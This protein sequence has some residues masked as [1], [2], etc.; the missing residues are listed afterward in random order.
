MK[1]PSLKTPHG[2][3][4]LAVYASLAAI[5]L[6]YITPD[7]MDT[8]EQIVAYYQQSQLELK[9]IF[10]EGGTLGVAIYLL[11]MVRDKKIWLMNRRQTDVKE[12]KDRKYRSCNLSL[13]W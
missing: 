5:A 11:D 1:K 10:R 7:S 8:V 12:R 6:S 3:H 4:V 2:R 13:V 9:D